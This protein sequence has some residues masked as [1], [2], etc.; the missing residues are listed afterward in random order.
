MNPIEKSLTTKENLAVVDVVVTQVIAALK[1]CKETQHAEYSGLENVWE[2]ICVHLQSDDSCCWEIY[3][4]TMRGFIILEL[5]K[6]TNNDLAALWLQTDDRFKWHAELE[7]RESPDITTLN[8]SIDNPSIP[9]DLNSIADFIIQEHLLSVAETYTNDNTSLYLNDERADGEDESPIQ[10]NINTEI[11]G[12]FDDSSLTNGKQP[13]VAIIMGGIA[14]GKTTLRKHQFASGYVIVDAAEI[15]LRL[16]KGEFYS[17]PDAFEE[18]M[19]MIGS[20]VASRAISERRNIVIELIGSEL[21]PLNKIIDAMKT[22]G[23]SINSC[24]VDLDIEQAQIRNLARGD[25]DISCY[26]AE[27]YHRRWL[28]EA[29]SETINIK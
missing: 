16:S 11:D 8:Q 28:E 27:P 7:Q 21:E 19:N 9:Y 6:L 12:F 14:A 2:E 29:A 4:D 24:Y 3:I 26:Y 25:D 10:I 20:L 5:E 13:E 17:F 23:Y 15:F 1:N 18:P 22:V